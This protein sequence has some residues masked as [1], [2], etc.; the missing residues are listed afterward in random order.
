MDEPPLGGRYSWL[1]VLLFGIHGGLTLLGL[2]LFILRSEREPV[3]SRNRT[4]VV[5]QALGGI[6]YFAPLVFSQPFFQATVTSVFGG[7]CEPVE[8]FMFPLAVPLLATVS[9]FFFFGL[10]V[11][12]PFHFFFF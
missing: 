6:G 7:Y 2:V 10:L 11:L 12:L 9:F 4:L 8:F 3:K 5:F 1:G